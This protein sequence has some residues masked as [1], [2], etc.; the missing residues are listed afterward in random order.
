MNDN[1]GSVCGYLRLI[2]EKLEDEEILKSEQHMDCLSSILTKLFDIQRAQ[3]MDNHF[4]HIVEKNFES[5]FKFMHVLPSSFSAYNMAALR[6]VDQHD[7]LLKSYFKS[8]DDKMVTNKVVPVEITPGGIAARIFL[9][10]T[11]WKM[12]YPVDVDSEEQLLY[13]ENTFISQDRI[14]CLGIH[15][16][17]MDICFLPDVFAKV[18]P[19]R[20]VN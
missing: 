6:P 19:I 11:L 17:N 1:V 7:E 8:I 14:L 9:P 18:E 12:I 20:M 15:K 2:E 10:K 3:Q 5:I 13:N 16:N 4:D